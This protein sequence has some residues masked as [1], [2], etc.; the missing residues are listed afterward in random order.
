MILREKFDAETKPNDFT[1]RSLLQVKN[2]NWHFRFTV[3][4]FNE[5]PPMPVGIEPVETIRINENVSINSSHF[6]L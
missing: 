5:R 2:E 3:L 4:D 6:N 1:C